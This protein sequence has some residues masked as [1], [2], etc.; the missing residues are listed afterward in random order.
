MREAET[1]ALTRVRDEINAILGGKVPTAPVAAAPAKAVTARPAKAVAA[2][3]GKPVLGWDEE[4]GGYG[5][6]ACGEGVFSVGESA[7]HAFDAHG[8]KLVNLVALVDPPE[9]LTHGRKWMMKKALEKAGKTAALE[10]YGRAAAVKAAK[11]KPV[12][13]A[14]AKVEA[15]TEAPKQRKWYKDEQGK[16]KKVKPEAPEAPAAE[17]KPAKKWFKKPAEETASGHGGRHQV[18]R[19]PHYLGCKIVF[20]VDGKHPDGSEKLS[21]LGKGEIVQE[22]DPKSSNFLIKFAG[23]VISIPKKSVV[24]FD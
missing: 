17:A 24:R 18:D 8:I 1:A 6:F 7:V 22:W 5:C 15:P 19:N 13:K 10:G 4:N 23:Q 14:P 21:D 2:P 16:W 20:R 3:A 9:S 11:P 12:A